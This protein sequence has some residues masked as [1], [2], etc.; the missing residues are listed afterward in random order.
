MQNKRNQTITIKSIV[1]IALGS[2]IT[3]IVG[4]AISMVS[5]A[6]TDHFTIINHSKRIEIVEAN[7][8]DKSIYE[9]NQKTEDEKNKAMLDSVN[10]L[11]KK[12]DKILDRLNIISFI[13]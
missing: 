13:K 6:N 10:K 11:D 5:L 3:G 7:K 8:L 4:T 9:A 2:F 1:A 12:V